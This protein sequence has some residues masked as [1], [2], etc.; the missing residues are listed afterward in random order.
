MISGYQVRNKLA[1][2]GPWAHSAGYAAF[3]QVGITSGTAGTRYALLQDSGGGTTFLNSPSQVKLRVNN[4]DRLVFPASGASAFTG[5]VSVSGDLTATSMSQLPVGQPNL[6]QHPGSYGTSAYLGHPNWTTSSANRF[7]IAQFAS[8]QTICNGQGS[9]LLRADNFTK[10]TIS[11][12]NNHTLQGNLSVSGTVSSSSD[13]S[14]KA[15]VQ[16]LSVNE[17][18]ALLAAVGPKEYVRID[19]GAKRCGFLANDFQSVVPE[20]WRDSI[21]QEQIWVDDEGAESRLLGL[22][23]GRLTTVLWAIVKDQQARIEAI[24]ARS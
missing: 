6:N 11:N 1:L 5:D 10:L 21:V 17:A 20:K 13:K 12:T 18:R 9:L 8:G 14:I 4:S 23:Y 19:T 2:I 22:D 24:E 16:D 15:D 3:E 7:A